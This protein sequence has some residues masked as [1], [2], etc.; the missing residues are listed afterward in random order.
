VWY[1]VALAVAVVGVAAAGAWGM[2]SVNDANARAD[3]F[4]SIA[5]PGTLTVQVTDPSDQMIYFTGSGSPSADA[6]A[7]KVEGPE[8]IAVE[9][10]PYDLTLEVDLAGDAGTAVATFAA[11]RQGTY[12]VTSTARD[13]PGVIAVGD[14]VSME[15]LPRVLGSLALMSISVGAAIIIVVVTLLRRS[16]RAS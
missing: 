4:P 9:T 5:L 6:L 16:S 2:R 1:L 14:N 8:G 3:A 13:H 7:L 10:V 15:V 11:E 12:T